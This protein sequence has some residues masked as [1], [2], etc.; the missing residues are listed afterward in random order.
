MIDK[1][2]SL[3]YRGLPL[4]RDPTG[5]ILQIS[6]VLIVNINYF[7]IFDETNA[8]FFFASVF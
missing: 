8:F 3:S 7:D 1:T 2:T 5:F 6:L 4:K